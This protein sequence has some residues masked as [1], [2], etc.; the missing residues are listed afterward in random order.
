MRIHVAIDNIKKT[1]TARDISDIV[2]RTI[3]VCLFIK[4]F[5]RKSKIS[6]TCTKN[7]LIY[8]QSCNRKTAQNTLSNIVCIK[9]F[10]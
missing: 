5:S 8:K 4:K 2:F 6:L 3:K 10:P 1:L 7:I 9:R